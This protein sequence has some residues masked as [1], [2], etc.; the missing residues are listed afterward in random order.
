MLRWLSI[1]AL[2]SFSVRATVFSP[3]PIKRQIKESTGFVKGQVL[4]LSVE[5]HQELGKVTRVFLRA[6]AWN[7]EEVKNNH[8]EIF[9]PGGEAG[10]ESVRVH[11]APKFTPGEKVVVFYNERE[12]KNWVSNL[13][14]GK[15]SIKKL[16][17]VEFMVNDI[18]PRMPN[19]GQMPL[20]GFFQ[21]ATDISEAPLKKRFK[22]KYERNAQRSK[23][24][25]RSLK[26]GRLPAS[27]S[28]S[29]A[30]RPSPLWLV[31][32]LG[33]GGIFVRA[34]KWRRRQ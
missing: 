6:D 17:Q 21:L 26:R 29:D 1:L 20:R 18:F 13:G 28:P 10:P 25:R 3:V 23:R 8:I 5:D 12:K 14:L 22:N 11:G 2:V 9:Y 16:G 34:F 15:F 30:K 7:G 24:S 27:A 31:L 33:A 19:V 32:L 4:S